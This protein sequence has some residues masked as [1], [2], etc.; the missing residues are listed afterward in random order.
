MSTDGSRPKQLTRSAG[1]YPSWSPDGSR[2]AF[3]VASAGAVQIGVIGRDGSGEH[4]IT[5]I[6]ENSEL[7]AWSPDGSR[8]AFCRGFEGERSIWTMR[9]DGTDARAITRTGNDDVG[10]VWSPDG[11]FIAFARSDELMLVR[12]DGSG[13]HTLG[14]RGSLPT[15]TAATSTRRAGDS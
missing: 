7:P 2:V 5:R 15:W 12:P 10:P 8:I 13:E 9:T 1:E 4:T 6:T 11:R 14:I 3:S